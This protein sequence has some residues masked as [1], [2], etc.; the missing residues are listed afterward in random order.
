MELAFLFVGGIICGIVLANVFRLPKKS[1]GTLDIDHK[2]ELATLHLDGLDLTSRKIKR[3]I[4]K[5]NHNADL[6]QN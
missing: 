3:V 2:N 4:L 1:L 5:V 6:S